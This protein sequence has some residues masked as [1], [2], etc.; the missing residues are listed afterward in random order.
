MFNASAHPIIII[1]RFT[2]LFRS[3]K[4][5]VLVDTG[6]NLEWGSAYTLECNVERYASRKGHSI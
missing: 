5:D 4:V 3:S 2:M 6:L 1:A